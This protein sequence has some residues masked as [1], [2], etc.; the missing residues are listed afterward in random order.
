MIRFPKLPAQLHW[1]FAKDPKA[2]IQSCENAL[3]YESP[4]FNSFLDLRI[5]GYVP[6]LVIEFCTLFR[7]LSDV[8]KEHKKNLF[9][10][11]YWHGLP[12]S[13]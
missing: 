11:F 7:A 13:G 10:I 4:R 8:A 5:F 1:L 9:R 6:D 2:L 12:P 3:C